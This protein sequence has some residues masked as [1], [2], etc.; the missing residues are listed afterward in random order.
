MEWNEDYFIRQLSSDKKYD[1]YWATIALR[2]C[3]KTKCISL[4]KKL[5]YYPM[6]DVKCTSILTIAHIAKS[7]ESIFYGECLLDPK[8]RDKT[9]AMWAINDAADERAIEVVHQYFK[10]NKSK[11]KS[12]KF[13]NGT[14]VDGCEYLSRFS[15][16]NNADEFLSFVKEIWSNLAEGERSELKKRINFFDDAKTA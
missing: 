8:Y 6:Q 14:L 12:G 13:T 1:V 2:D 10:K 15:E 4:L 5:I 16:D 9:Y 3:G 11:I 7:E